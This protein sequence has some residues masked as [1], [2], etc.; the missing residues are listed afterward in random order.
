[1]ERQLKFDLVNEL[2][3][4]V[5]DKDVYQNDVHQ[6]RV[7]YVQ[8]TRTLRVNKQEKIDAQE[9]VAEVKKETEEEIFARLYAQRKG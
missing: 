8:N 6:K 4:A 2:S 1:M 5:T 7:E 3:K 9:Q